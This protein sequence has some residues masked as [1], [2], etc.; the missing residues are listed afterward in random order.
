MAFLS[1]APPPPDEGVIVEPQSV[2]AP[3]LDLPP[4]SKPP[5]SQKPPQVVAIE[6]ELEAFLSE[7]RTMPSA[8]TAIASV[9]DQPAP[10]PLPTR[11]APT[12]TAPV[13]RPSQTGMPAQ[14][15]RPSPTISERQSAPPGPLSGPPRA[16]SASPLLIDVTPLSLGVETVGGFC[17]IIIRANSP[18]PCDRSRIFRTASDNQTAVVVK[19]CQGES[20]RFLENTTLGDLRLSGFRAAPRGEVE[21]S[22][23]FEIDADGIL[24]VQ[25]KE[26]STGRSAVARIELLG[27]HMDP[28]KMQA[29]IDRQ[30]RREVA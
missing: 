16:T 25:A 29:M 19:V 17:D 9:V 4:M 22:V 24:N 5:P 18:V 6:S 20:D 7:D 23:T 10:P 26:T 14:T 28:K 12:M 13:S 15:A 27:A 1:D 2:E 21:I 8:S 3:D 30:A 11:G